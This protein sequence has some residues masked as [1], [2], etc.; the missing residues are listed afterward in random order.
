MILKKYLVVK[1]QY[2]IILTILFCLVYSITYINQ[3]NKYNLC[4]WK[5]VDKNSYDKNK[6]KLIKS[7]INLLNVMKVVYYL[8]FG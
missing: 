3:I 5:V 4:K 2:F 7:F 8:G 1:I 6:T